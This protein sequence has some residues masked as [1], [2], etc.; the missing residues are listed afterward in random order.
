VNW[1]PA[2]VDWCRRTS[3]KKC[4]V[5]VFRN[6]LL[7][8]CVITLEMLCVNNLRSRVVAAGSPTSNLSI[9]IIRHS[10]IA[11]KWVYLPNIWLWYLLDVML[12]LHLKLVA[13]VIIEHITYYMR[14]RHTSNLAVSAI[15]IAH[16]YVHRFR[17]AKCAFWMCILKW[18][19]WGAGRFSRLAVEYAKWT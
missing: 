13:M 8:Y 2:N 7:F 10:L 16:A 3:L 5:I 18:Y 12:F 9:T 17:F 19:R 4:R 11:D 14:H 15:D 1:W 6:H